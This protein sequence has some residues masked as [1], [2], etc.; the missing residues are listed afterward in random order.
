MEQLLINEQLR[1]Q[2]TLKG[3]ERIKVFDWR[4]AAQGFLDLFES[5][6]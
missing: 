3:F 6:C 2:L 1:G 5:F 4:L